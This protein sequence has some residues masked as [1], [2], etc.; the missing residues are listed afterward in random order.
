MSQKSYRTLKSPKTGLGLRDYA[1]KIEWS[2]K[3]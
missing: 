1:R 2:N 3:S